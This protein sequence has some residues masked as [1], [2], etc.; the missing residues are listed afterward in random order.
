MIDV[1]IDRMIVLYVWGGSKIVANLRNILFWHVHY[2]AESLTFTCATCLWMQGTLAHVEGIPLS[3]LQA[4]DVTSLKAF[5][6]MP[7]LRILILDGVA[8]DGLQKGP[9]SSL[10]MLSRRAGLTASSLPPGF[11][12]PRLAMVSW[13]DISGPSLPFLLNLIKSAAVL[14]ISGSSKLNRLPGNLQVWVA[15]CSLCI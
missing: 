10:A 12:L 5:S 6:R 1:V 9:V 7:L 2:D 4:V 15:T 3:G 11:H 14:D 13:R 8:M